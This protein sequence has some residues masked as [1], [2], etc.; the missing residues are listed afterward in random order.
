MFNAMLAR[1]KGYI[2]HGLEVEVP[3]FRSTLAEVSEQREADRF[4]G[5]IAEGLNLLGSTAVNDKYYK[6]LLNPDLKEDDSELDRKIEDEFEKKGIYVDLQD[7]ELTKEEDSKS[8]EQYDYEATCNEFAKHVIPVLM[9]DSGLKA[10][11]AADGNNENAIA[12]VICSLAEHLKSTAKDV[13]LKKLGE[14]VS[15][16]CKEAML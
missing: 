10:L 1:F 15:E 8:D 13:E 4:A 11:A 6:L 9:S 16:A 5:S 14:N 2:K 7:D 12:W 3:K